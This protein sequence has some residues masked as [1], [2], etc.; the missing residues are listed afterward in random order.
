[1]KTPHL[2]A[3]LLILHASPVLF[4]EE[5]FRE[6]FESPPEDSALIEQL[7]H[8]KT[9]SAGEP[10]P[11]A[12]AVILAPG[13]APG[14]DTKYLSTTPGGA[15]A[16]TQNVSVEFSATGESLVISVD[17]LP[18][19]GTGMVLLTTPEG[20][21]LHPVIVQ[22]L[23]E[24]AVIRAASKNADGE[25]EMVKIGAFLANRWHRVTVKLRLNG[26]A[27]D[28]S[29]YDVS[30][31]NLMDESTT[32]EA[33]GLKCAAPARTVNGVILS[34]TFGSTSLY[35]WDNLVVETAP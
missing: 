35:G 34:T 24:G 18:V 16:T 32:A 6:T 3:A 11:E 29:H 21:N 9:N 25:T 28:E 17:V 20:A 7:P 2:L 33:K 13:G 4:A 22:F 23:G 27:E 26:P 8:W 5:L 14:N 31:V 19:Q 1:M 15:V 12:K 30:V 10:N